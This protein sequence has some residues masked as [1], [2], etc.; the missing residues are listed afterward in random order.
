MS[1]PTGTATP[2]WEWTPPSS[3]DVTRKIR[4]VVAGMAAAIAVV[5]ALAIVSQSRFTIVL[6]VLVVSIGVF[7]LLEHRRFMST[8]C[9]I[10]ADGTLTMSD[11]RSTVA[12]DVAEA[13]SVEIRRRSSGGG[14]VSATGRWSIEIVGSAGAVHHTMANVAGAF[15]LPEDDVR[16]L[17]HEL[18][19]HVLGT[20]PVPD[21]TTSVA[22]VV[23][24]LAAPQYQR[25]AERYEWAP[26]LSPN[27]DRNR[28]LLRAAFIIPAVGIALYAVVAYREEGVVA[29]LLSAATVPGMLLLG[30]WALDRAMAKGRTFR[31][32]AEAGQ[33]HVGVPGKAKTVPLAGSKIAIE[34]RNQTTHSS[35][36]TAVHTTRWDLDVATASGDEHRFPFPS[37]G[38]VTNRDDYIQLERELQQR[39]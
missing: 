19:S 29:V 4:R 5:V 27:A 24:S 23:S 31:V 18:R 16:A 32:N 36:G 8:R 34:L 10:D 20:D 38:T 35:N 25:P 3:D 33:L 15:N 6:A 1:Q 2:V 14:G 12:I 39:A 13:E 11:S 28:W 26:R 22:A 17:E 7:W 9:V 21:P 30:A 37:F